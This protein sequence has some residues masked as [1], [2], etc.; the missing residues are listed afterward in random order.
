[1]L[2]AW[3]ELFGILPFHLDQMTFGEISEFISYYNRR[4]GEQ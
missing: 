4:A 2:P 1:M 3:A